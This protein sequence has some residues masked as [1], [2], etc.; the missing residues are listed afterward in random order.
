METY[1]ARSDRIIRHAESNVAKQ[2]NAIE[3][4]KSAGAATDE[5]ERVLGLMLNWLDGLRANRRRVES[6]IAARCGF[7]AAG[8]RMDQAAVSESAGQW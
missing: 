4:L 2:R 7:A 5:A 6:E 1:L 3:K 8:G